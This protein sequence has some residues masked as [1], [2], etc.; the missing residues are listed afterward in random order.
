VL[1]ALTLVSSDPERRYERQDLIP[2]LELAWRAALAMEN[3]RLHEQAQRANR[4]RKEMMA[5]VS[6]DLRNP[7]GAIALRALALER[8]AERLG[9][10]STVS[11]AQALQR[12]AQQMERLVKDM[13]DLAA[14]EAGRLTIQPQPQD[15]GPL[16][17]ELEEMLLPLGER[18][19]VRVVVHRPEA[20]LRLRCDRNRLIQMLSNLAG[21]ALKFTPEGGQVTVR[22]TQEDTRVHLSVSDT[23]PGIAPEELPHIF[24]RYWRAQSASRTAGVGLGLAIVKGIVEAHGGSVHAESRPGEGSTFRVL[25]PPCG[26]A[27]H[28]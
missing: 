12:S 20:S 25:L 7:L 27:T 9:D 11:D 22:A 18:S 21:N 5:V 3:A 16:L 13:L 23:G 10:T 8:R 15:L 14:I 26:P 24:D 28:G 4:M 17:T 19:G 6:H 2:A 1:G